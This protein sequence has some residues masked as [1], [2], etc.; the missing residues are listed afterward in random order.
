M[1]PYSGRLCQRCNTGYYPWFGTCQRC[2]DDFGWTAA[3]ALTVIYRYGIIWLLWLFLNRFLCERLQMADSLLN[4]AQ[5]AG[6]LGAF[7]LDWPEGLSY[8]LG[9]C[10]ILDF[11]IDVTG[12]FASRCR[13]AGYTC[14][15]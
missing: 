7:D 4:F 6:V 13:W 2:P 12:Y 5:I 10:G 15:C 11:D 1:Q 3:N 9:L 14:C 8:F